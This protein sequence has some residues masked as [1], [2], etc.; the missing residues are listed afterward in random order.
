MRFFKGEGVEDLTMIGSPSNSAIV[1]NLSARLNREQIYTGLGDVLISVNPYK[2][3]NIYGDDV[4]G[5]YKAS[6]TSSNTAPHIFRTAQLAYSKLIENDYSQS[7]IISGESGAGK[8]VAAKFLLQYFVAVSPSTGGGSNSQST[9]VSQAPVNDYG[10]SPMGSRSPPPPR[11]GGRGG[12]ARGGGARGAGRGGGG[13][14]GGARGGGG[15][16]G[17]RGGARGGPPNRGARGR[18]GR[19]GGGAGRGRGGGGSAK[20]VDEIKKIIIDSNPILEAFGNAKT[21]RNN[22]SSRFGKYL[23]IQFEGSAPIGGVIT[24][25]LLESTRVAFQGKN[26]RNFHIFYYVFAGCDGSLRQDLGFG[27]DPTFF[28]YLGQSGC[29]TID[30]VNDAEEFQ[31]VCNALSTVGIGPGEQAEIWKIIAAILWL[32][33][34]NFT[35]SAPAKVTDRSALEY[36]A[37][38]LQVEP[39]FLET[40]LTHKYIISG[41]ARH[42][43]YQSPQ[44][45]DQSIAVRDALAKTLYARVF[46]YIVGAINVALSCSKSTNVIGLLDI[47]GFEIFEHN[48]F[49]QF[50]INF[51]NEMLQQIFI[52]LTIKAGAG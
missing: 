28:H 33:N 5:M 35:G 34:I 8:T 11:P 45:A 24:S 17:A 19:G 3:L 40:S 26:E 32:G 31:I 6:A 4:I 20:T 36:A 42:T 9:S 15:R 22:N 43:E 27:N 49:E 39:G 1:S 12:G 30:E 51:V 47:Y 21:V 7:I 25:F 23:E 29:T 48:S 46:D 10:T 52:E 38:L 44:N 13:R 14:G 37:Y 18:G 41:S 16:G 50:C 2:R